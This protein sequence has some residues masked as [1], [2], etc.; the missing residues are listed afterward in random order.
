MYHILVTLGNLGLKS[1]MEN[2]FYKV[3]LRKEVLKIV[4]IKVSI[5]I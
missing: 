5:Q 2:V 4:C 3:A 1:A